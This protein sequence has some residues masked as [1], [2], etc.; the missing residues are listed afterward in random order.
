MHGAGPQISAEMRRRG[1]AVRVRRRTAR[2]DARTGSRW[3]ASRSPRSTRRSAPAIGRSR[4]AAVR[5]RDRARRAARCRS[6][7]SSATRCRA[8]RRRSS[9]ARRRA[10]PRR[11]AARGRPPER[12]RR[13]G[14]VGAR[15]RAR[16][17]AGSSSSPTCLA[18]CS[19][20]RSCRRSTPADA[21]GLLDAGEL[22]GG[23]V[24]KL[25]AAV[26]AAQAR[27]PGRDRRDGGAGV[28]TALDRPRAADLRAAGRHLRLRRGL[29]ARRRHG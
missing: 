16:R 5:R 24:P 12:Q 29:V 27:R 10:D 20:A 1:L 28:S 15:D 23:I 19:R 13:R 25:R 2:D 18:C 14:R 22:E 9:R 8:A 17:G 4:R 7:G 6:S 26:I 3:C 11:R 21:Q